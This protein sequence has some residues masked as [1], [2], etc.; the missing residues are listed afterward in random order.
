M[1][2]RI[3]AATERS[4]AG[5]PISER[6]MREKEELLSSPPRL[7]TERLK[8]MLEVYQQTEGI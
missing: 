2:T 5:R 7:D 6:V 1:G 8:F 4:I 3:T